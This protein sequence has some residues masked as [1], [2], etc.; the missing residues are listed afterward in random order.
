MNVLVHPGFVEGDREQIA[1]LYWQAF[2]G[3]LA[4][5]MGPPEKALHYISRVASPRHAFSARDQDGALLGIAGF[6]THDGA[7]VG[8]DMADLVAVYGRLGALWRAGLLA[9]LEREV[10]NRRFLIDGIAV[11][12]DMRGRGIGSTLV[13][14]LCDAARAEGYT[15]IRL[16]VIAENIRARALYERLGFAPLR[17]DRSRLM[18]AVFGFATATT[19]VRAL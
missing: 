9:L 2:G 16:D 13:E 5:V 15:E 12:D 1:G 14:A 19:M 7:L 4:R 10:E 8:G 3:K 11:R 18:A 17:T 6:K